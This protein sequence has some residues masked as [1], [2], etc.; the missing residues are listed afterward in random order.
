MSDGFDFQCPYCNRHSAITDERFD[1]W[2]NRITIPN[3]EGDQVFRGVVIVC[4]NPKCRKI[5]FSMTRGSFGGYSP[6][7]SDPKIAKKFNEWDLLPPSSARPLP[8]YVP[9]P[10]RNDYEEACAIASL[11]PKASATLARRCLQGMIRDFWKVKGRTLKDEID[12][13]QTKVESTTW[14]AIDAVRQLGNIGA[15]M[16]Q[17]INVIVDVDDGEAEA[18]LRLIETLIDDW[19]VARHD[20]EERLKSVI[21]IAGSKKAAKAVPSPQ[22]ATPTPAATPSPPPSR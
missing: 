7:V 5:K 1:I 10:I 2:T 18:M 14:Q 6:G 20:R 22:S 4:P 19:Y 9:N 3:A 8:D 12:G 16:E 15:H 13:L 21:A 17:D 11:S